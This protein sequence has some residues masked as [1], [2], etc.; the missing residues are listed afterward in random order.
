MST[1]PTAAEAKDSP[2]LCQEA[3]EALLDLF[4]TMRRSMREALG[5]GTHALAPMQLRMLRH[6]QRHPGASQ[7]TLVQASGR[8]KG[9]V[10]RMVKELE[11]QGLLTREADPDDGRSQRLRL[12]A[13]GRAACERFRRHEAAIAQRMF[14]AMSAREL[15]ALI[16]QLTAMRARL[17][18][19]DDDAA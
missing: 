5:A 4:A 6:C 17:K 14:G 19:S 10:A 18:P 8:D 7:Q 15:Q 9:Q 13:A 1:K 16:D 12:T 11:A 2:E 3:N